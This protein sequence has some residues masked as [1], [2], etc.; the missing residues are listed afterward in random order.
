MGIKYLF[1]AIAVMTLIA[2]AAPA[3]PIKIAVTIFPVADLTGR[4]LK[5]R[6]EM[7]TILPPGA[8]PHTFSPTPRLVARLADVRVLVMVGTGLDDWAKKLVA[9]GE[10]GPIIIEL[11]RGL[12]LIQIH[13]E[14]SHGRSGN[15]H[16]WLDPVLMKGAVKTIAAALVKAD[17]KGRAVYSRGLAEVTA[18][19]TA[20]DR[21]IRTRVA[22]WRHRRYVA[23]HPFLAYFA[24]RYGLIRVGVIEEAP[25]K[26]PTPRH[27]M[28]IVAAIKR[29]KVGFVL[30]EPQLND[31]AARV[32]AAEAGVR[33]MRVDPLGGPRTRYGRT[34]FDLMRYNVGQMEK[35]M[36]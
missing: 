17:P 8:S 7:I 23:F 12:P 22:K 3:K 34:Y 29:Y 16:V 14:H 25:G 27:L 18:G 19:L 31:K 2:T 5:G 15:P 26:R 1:S 10:R 33:V 6:A 24:K 32:I 13:G 28:K 20:L 11:S 35:A 4:I 9:A 30:A 36:K 21:E